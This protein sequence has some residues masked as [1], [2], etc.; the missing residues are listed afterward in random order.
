MSEIG[1][2]RKSKDQYLGGD[3]NSPLT[4]E[5]RKGFKGLKY[6]AENADLQFVLEVEE[7]PDD[8]KDLIQMATSSGDS[9]PHIRW[10][11][12][13][14]VVGG[15]PVAL[16]VY[17]ATKTEGTISCRSWTPRRGMIRTQMDAI[18]TCRFPATAG[19]GLQLR[20]QPELELSHTPAREP[21]YGS[22]QCR[23]E[24]VS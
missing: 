15:A 7:Y 17:T 2:F 14:F 10:G 9:A 4:P 13:R 6:F 18:L 1:D 16:T 23:G 11:Q 24:E 3:P 21:A 19:G 8:S 5:Q 20:L 22:H 12:L